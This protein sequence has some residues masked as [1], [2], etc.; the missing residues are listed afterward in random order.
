MH[1]AQ[2]KCNPTA[3]WAVHLSSAR[4][5]GLFIDVVGA[6]IGMLKSYRDDDRTIDSVGSVWRREWTGMVFGILICVYVVCRGGVLWN[7]CVK[8]NVVEV[9]RGVESV[10]R[11]MLYVCSGV[12]VRKPV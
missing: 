7:E 4:R 6:L 2:I 10:Q 12:N 1:V 8:L 3:S 11:S 5:N 9:A